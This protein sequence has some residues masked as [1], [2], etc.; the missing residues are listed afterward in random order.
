VGLLPENK[1]FSFI[2]SKW[3][4]YRILSVTLPEKKCQIFCMKVDVVDVLAILVEIRLTP[5]TARWGRQHILGVLHCNASKLMT[6][7]LKHD[8]I[9]KT[10]Y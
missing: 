8:K 10:I 2:Y 6:E 4:V 7:I 3:H 9:W 1:K 5:I